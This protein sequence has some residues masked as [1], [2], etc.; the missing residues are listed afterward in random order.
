M[1]T[2]I[3]TIEDVRLFAFQLVNEENLS[4][5]PDDDFADYINVETKET[6]YSDKEVKMLNNL[7]EKCFD[8]CQ[9]NEVD[10]YDLMGQPLFERMKIGEY[11]DKN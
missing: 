3:N 11:A 4:F 9:Q 8:I 7:M 2:E 5:H 10:I 1:I 6:T